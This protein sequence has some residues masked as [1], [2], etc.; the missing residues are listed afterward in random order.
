MCGDLDDLEARPLDGTELAYN[1]FFSPDG[2]W[3]GFFRP[4]SLSTF[5]LKR[6]AVG[7]GTPLTLGKLSGANGATWLPDGSIIVPHRAAVGAVST[8]HR[9]PEAGGTPEP[10]TTPDAERGEASQFWPQALPGGTDVLFTTFVRGGPEW[11]M[12][13]A[14]VAVLSLD[15]GEQ[16]VVVEGGFNARYLPTGHLVFGRDGAVWGVPFDLDRLATTGPEE[17]VLQGVEVNEGGSMALS[18]SD[19]GTLVYWPGDAVDLELR[20]PVGG[21][22]PCGSTATGRPH[23]SG[24]T[25]ATSCIPAC[26]RTIRDSP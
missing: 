16:H 12:N 20:T 6:V 13:A 18:V 11:T 21:A 9:I 4:L 14:S 3:V 10:L 7:G 1:P 8:L 25:G 22:G 26:H 24:G 5:E 23:R 19:D 17:V 2:Q 15:T